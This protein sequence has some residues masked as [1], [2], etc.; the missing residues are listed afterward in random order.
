MVSK[1]QIGKH[2]N[3]TGLKC[4]PILEYNVNYLSFNMTGTSKLRVDK[5]K[6]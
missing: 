2:K 1:F 3:T 5:T 6:A 4:K